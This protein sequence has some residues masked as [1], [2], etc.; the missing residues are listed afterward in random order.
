MQACVITAA[1]VYIDMMGVPK[2]T[3]SIRALANLM[4]RAMEQ[5][6]DTESN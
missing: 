4:I 6:G 3:D 2:T 1:A 5:W